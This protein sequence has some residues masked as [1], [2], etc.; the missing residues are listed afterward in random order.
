MARELNFAGTV[1][2][3]EFSIMSCDQL[4]AKVKSGITCG[5]IR[6]A[7]AGLVTKIGDW[8]WQGKVE[9]LSCSRDHRSRLQRYH[10]NIMLVRIF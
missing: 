6:C 3:E 9:S 2:Q 10:V 1:W 8:P 5:R 7:R 4:R